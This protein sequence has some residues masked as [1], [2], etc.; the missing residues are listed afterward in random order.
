MKNGYLAFAVLLF[1]TIMQGCAGSVLGDVHDSMTGT[2]SGYLTSVAVLDSLALLPPPPA[3]GSAA[4]ALDEEV[5][6]KCLAFKG[7]PRWDLAAQDA[8][9]KFPEASGTFACALGA[10]ITAKDM[11]HLYTLLI[12]TL[13]DAGQTT[14]K[15]KDYYS[16]ARPFMVNKEPSCTPADE[17]ALAKNGS[18]PS[19]HT[20]IGWA[21]AL[22]LTEL[23]P[24]R[25]DE[26]LARGFAF[27]ESRLVC[28]VHWQ[29]DVTAGRIMGAAMVARLHADPSFRADLEA[30][31]AE[32]AAVRARG[33]KP[34]RNCAAEAAALGK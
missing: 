6:R 7:K 2:Q 17:N 18:Y 11:P 24:D 9:L 27:G 33:L 10:P 12:R 3:K 8:V 34:R 32:L 19:G 23:A 20:T 4:M 22:I 26:I 1:I 25:A 29:S 31:R 13:A 16:R 28:N 5:N 14:K 21:W 30:A 15:A